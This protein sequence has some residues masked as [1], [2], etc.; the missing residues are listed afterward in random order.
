MLFRPSDLER[1]EAIGF[2]QAEHIQAQARKMLK[3]LMETMKAPDYASSRAL[4]IISSVAN[5]GTKR[6]DLA[7][8]IVECLV[9]IPS[10]L[11]CFR[12]LIFH[13]WSAR[14]TL[15]ATHM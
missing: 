15:S 8:F 2:V 3:M 9:R 10:L 6:H 4:V 1:N 7:P 12:A 5:V 11:Y 13:V 14:L